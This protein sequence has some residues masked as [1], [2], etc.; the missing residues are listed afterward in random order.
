MFATAA[1]LLLVLAIVRLLQP[2]VVLALLVVSAI[3]WVWTIY[4]RRFFLRARASLARRDFARALELFERDRERGISWLNFTFY[5]ADGDAAREN[6]IAVCL[7][8]LG[9]LEDAEARFRALLARD[10]DYAMPHLNLGFIA[11]AR[12]DK[13]GALKYFSRARELGYSGAKI[14]VA[15][16]ATLAKFNIGL[17]KRV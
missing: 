16:R 7:M 5:T 4:R 11:D 14:D 1:I 15:I 9:R 8:G 17:G 2:D 13:D 6:N 12:G 10:P 3:L